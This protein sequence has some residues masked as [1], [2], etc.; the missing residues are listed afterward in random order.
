MLASAILPYIL[1][2]P[3]V[4]CILQHCY[5]LYSNFT[6][7]YATIHKCSLSFQPAYSTTICYQP[8][9]LVASTYFLLLRDYA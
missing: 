9:H 5:L 1:L 6:Y 7:Y 2:L 4:T 3:G 8:I